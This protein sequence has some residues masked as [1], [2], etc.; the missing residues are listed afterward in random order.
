MHTVYVATT[1]PG[2]IPEI[3]AVLAPLGF[4]VRLPES[5][6]HVEETGST[7][8]ANARLKARAAA[9]AL[10]APALADD[11]GLCVDVLDGAP[12]VR[13]ARFAG[14]DATD[15]DNNR[16]LVERL[17]ALGVAD[18]TAR[19]VCHV[20][21]AAPDGRILAEGEGALEGVIRWPEQ[22]ENGFGYD[23]LFHHPESGCRTAELTP[24]AK[25]A[26]SHRGRALRALAAALADSEM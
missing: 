6:P 15:A 12:G 21:L 3:Q 13:S 1:N 8:A 20:T 9:E 5:L 19:F 16:L 26:I 7:F 14:P 22:G 25:N 10:G 17:E 24:E 4:D 18:P 11:S 2:K 23:P